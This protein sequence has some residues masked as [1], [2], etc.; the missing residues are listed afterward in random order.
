[1]RLHW[2]ALC[3]AGTVLSRVIEQAPLGLLNSELWDDTVELSSVPDYSLKVKHPDPAK[4]GIDTV[5]QYSGYLDSEKTDRHFFYWAFESR[6]DPASDPVILWLNGG[7]GCSS[8]TGLFYELGPSSINRT[9]DPVFNPYSWNNNATVIFLDQPV[10]VGFSYSGES[11]TNS[12]AAGEDVY[13]FLELFFHK[14]PQ[15]SQLGLHVAGESYAGIYIPMIATEILKHPLRGFKFS[16]VLIGNGITDPEVQYHYYQPMVCGEGG[17]PQIASD[18]DC[19]LM[20][21][22]ESRCENLILACYRVPNSVT[23]VPAILYCDQKVFELTKK[24]GFNPYDVR[25]KCTDDCY[26]DTAYFTEYLNRPYI[27][28]ELGTRATKY[29]SCSEEVFNRFLL[30]GDQMKPYQE[31]VAELLDEYDFPVLVY[32]GDKD[33]ICNWLGGQAW[34]NQ[35][36]YSNKFNFQAAPVKDY[37]TLNGTIAGEVKNYDK[38]TFLRVFEAGHMVPKDQ[39]ESSLD[40]VNR[41][42]SGEYGL[43]E[44]R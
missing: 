4:L 9:I 30:S 17:Y 15:F 33:Y 19:I 2:L 7:P 43:S 24:Y 16:S 1:M 10:G 6:N 14:F 34:T 27:Q 8:F 32:S 12:K 41:W 13:A 35:L 39:P 31:K 20:R 28:Q 21:K 5:K 29:D 40:F 23:C 18:E 36:E 25:D 22:H 44:G 38:F 3:C 26:A 11:V 37:Y 42:I